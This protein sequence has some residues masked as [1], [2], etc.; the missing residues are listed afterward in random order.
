MPE[1]DIPLLDMEASASPVL[2]ARHKKKPKLS[3]CSFCIGLVLLFVG[4]VVSVM[5]YQLGTLAVSALGTAR[6][7][8]L[9]HHH[10]K[11]ESMEEVGEDKLVRSFFSPWRAGDGGV[12]TF[13]L[14]VTIY[15]RVMVRNETMVAGGKG[16]LG[17]VGSLEEEGTK[18]EEEEDE[19]DEEDEFVWGPWERIHSECVL[20]GMDMSLK[21]VKAVTKVVLPGRIM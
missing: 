18:K 19:E 3:P 16:A 6:Y 8:H 11:N 2:R 7:P 12:E 13:D 1:H 10:P 20:G 9:A 5:V 17:V 4:S 15:Y 21:R 14:I